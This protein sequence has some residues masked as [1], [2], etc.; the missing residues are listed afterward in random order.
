MHCVVKCIWI[1]KGLKYWVTIL[2]I[3]TEVNIHFVISNLCN[4]VSL[5]KYYYT[6]V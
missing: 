2:I 3:N 4:E 1:S 5:L 6:S